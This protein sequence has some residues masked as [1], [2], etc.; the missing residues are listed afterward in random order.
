MSIIMLRQIGGAGK[1]DVRR[2]VSA[3]PEHY[4]IFS[5][6]VGP[7]CMLRTCG[8]EPG[9][10]EQRVVPIIVWAGAAIEACGKSGFREFE[11]IREMHLHQ[12][13]N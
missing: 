5:N 11:F 10:Q 3:A 12:L 13:N 2:A 7:N 1:L 6:E 9:P 8:H 4:K